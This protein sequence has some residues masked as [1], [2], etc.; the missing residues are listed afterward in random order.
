MLTLSE[1]GMPDEMILAL[2][3]YVASHHYDE[4]ERAALEYGDTIILSG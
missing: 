4:E 2:E 1:L 3:D